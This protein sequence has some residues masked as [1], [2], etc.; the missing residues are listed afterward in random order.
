MWN[1]F[2]STWT[3]LLTKFWHNILF[4]GVYTRRK[5]NI[6][7]KII[8]SLEFSWKGGLFLLSHKNSPKRKKNCIATLQAG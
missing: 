4:G 2:A 6:D 1:F 5:K 8:P 3:V 7:S